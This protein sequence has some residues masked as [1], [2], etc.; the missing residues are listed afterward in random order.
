MKTAIGLATAL[1][2]AVST[3]H[4]DPGPTDDNGCHGGPDAHHCHG[5]GGASGEALLVVAAVAAGTAYFVRK[6]VDQ[7]RLRRAAE[8]PAPA[9]R[10]YD[11]N[12]NG[13]ISC[14]EARRHGIAPAPREHAAYP[15]MR[16][17]D[18]DGVACEGRSRSQAPG[19]GDVSA[20]L[21]RE[22]R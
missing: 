4:A 20:A 16:D 10:R 18:K 12:R 14:R 6:A 8:N 22:T 3:A 19:H 13:S 21:S 5:G 7:R 17:L 9:L 2:L 1:W 11:D 15:Y